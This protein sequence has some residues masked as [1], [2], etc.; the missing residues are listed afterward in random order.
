MAVIVVMAMKLAELTLMEFEVN[1]KL[2]QEQQVERD[3]RLPKLAS[4]FHQV[5]EQC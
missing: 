1:S 4:A 3:L 5:Q 2:S